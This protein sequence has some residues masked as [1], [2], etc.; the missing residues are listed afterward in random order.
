MHE[1]VLREFIKSGMTRTELANRMG[2]SLSRVSKWLSA[3]GNWE[4]DTVSDF[5]L[6]INGGELEPSIARPFE[7]AK[8]NYEQPEWLNKAPPPEQ[9][10]KRPDLESLGLLKKK[11]EAPQ[12]DPKGSLADQLR[13]A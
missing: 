4:L 11:P 2:R 8:R 5:L 6:A 9:Q 12:H 3:P 7:Q 13:A 10:E 1:L